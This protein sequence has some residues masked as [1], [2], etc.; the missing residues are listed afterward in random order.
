MNENQTIKEWRSRA[1]RDNTEYLAKFTIRLTLQLGPIW[2]PEFEDFTLW[3]EQHLGTKY[4]DW[5]LVSAGRGRYTLHAR[6]SKWT[7][8]LLLKTVDFRID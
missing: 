6:D 8:F 1:D 3:C 2:D 5:F 7:T 4:K